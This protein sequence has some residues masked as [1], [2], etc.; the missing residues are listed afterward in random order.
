MLRDRVEG[1]WTPRP[2]DLG[3]EPGGH[4][5]DT[6]SSLADTRDGHRV[7]VHA[8]ARNAAAAREALR[9]ADLGG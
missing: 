9:K 7:L 2:A 8:L 5:L 3:H 1:T 6:H 4:G